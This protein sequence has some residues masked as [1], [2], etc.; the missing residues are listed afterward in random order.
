MAEPGVDE[1][2][3]VAALR[4]PV[5]WILSREGPGLVAVGGETTGTIAPNEVR[6]A[7][8]AERV[9]TGVTES[10]KPSG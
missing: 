2:G 7:G 1:E 10:R 3:L 6:S 8:I 9:A 5:I 4:A